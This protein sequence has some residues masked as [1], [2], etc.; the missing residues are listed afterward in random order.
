MILTVPDSWE[1]VSNGKLVSVANA[2]QGMKVWTWR[3]A[4]PV[5]TYLI[6]VVAGQF[7]KQSDTW[8][9]IPV[10]YMVPH[11]DRDR[12]TP[13]F[14]HT[15]DMLTF[16]SD[17]FG[18][19]YP[20]AK[21]DQSTVDQF[22]ESGMEN[23]SA[24]TLTTRDLVNPALAKESIEG[25][26]PL[27]SHE[28]GHQWFGDLV[29]CNDW[30]NLWL[31]EGFATFL[32]QLWE[33]HEYGSDAA[34]YARWREQNGWRRQARL[35]TVPIVNSDFKDSMD[36][37]GNIYG[38]G[39]L[40]LEM[41]R[42]Q[43]G[44]DAFFRGLQH[45]LEANRLKTVVT[46]DLLKALDESSGTKVDQF[47]DQ[48]IY[49]AG[50]PQFEIDSE[51]D[52]GAK[53]LN[54]TVMQAQKTAGRM[55]LFNVPIEVAISTAIDTK[56]FPITVSKQ[57]ETFSFPVDS[58]PLLVLFDKGDKILKSVNFH[59]TTAQWIYQL[60]NAQDVPDRADAAQALAGIKGDEAVAA[61][62]QAAIH[63]HFWGVRN[64]ALLAL[65]RI[66]GSEAEKQIMAG[67]VNSDPWVR[68]TAMAQL[69]RF[70]DDA[71]LAPKLAEVFRSDIAFRVRSAALTSY[72]QLKPAGGLAFLQDAARIDS[73][74]DVIR[75]AALK[76]MGALGNDMA[77]STLGDWSEQGKPIDLRTAAI[78][79]LAELD[80]KD[81]TVESQLIADLNDP[82]FDVRLATIFALGTR[83]DAAAIAPLEAM[84]NRDDLSLGLAPYIQRE[85]ARLRKDGSDDDGPSA[86]FA[87]PHPVGTRPHANAA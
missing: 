52:S 58:R 51:Y 66:G 43:M 18:V 13:T 60:Q 59:K 14:A 32:A 68:E 84:L 12:I 75:R 53:K 9:D 1:T 35:Y 22:T 63:D 4:L 65:G 69:G 34:A 25:A 3:Q 87:P 67:T 2:G 44:D 8:H 62:G 80:K 21:Y 71:T 37:A 40:V 5:S 49:G 7:D 72:A 76:A 70:H 86:K 11:G 85:L 48:W 19:L 17:R 27:T 41:L 78:S 73:P 6:S 36:Y 33:E 10:D 64:E 23:V 82:E 26:D 50:A 29:T 47:F 38:K 81:E 30:S 16:F 79:S 15:R 77:V 83:G 55:G 42:E 45:Y 31:N 46:A 56:S 61:L 24:T 39:G 74:D 28:L 54:L 20:W 57:E